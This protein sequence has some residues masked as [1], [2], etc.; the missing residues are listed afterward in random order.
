MVRGTNQMF[1]P[2]RSTITQ[3]PERLPE[4]PEQRLR[5]PSQRRN[6]SRFRPVR[7]PRNRQT[8]PPLKLRPVSLCERASRRNA[9]G[10]SAGSPDADKRAPYGSQN[11]ADQDV[12][13]TIAKRAAV[14][15]HV[16]AEATH[17]VVAGGI[18]QARQHG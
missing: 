3:P 11:G 17:L 14:S 1:K 9:P 10:A 5:Q 12:H 15:A 8:R 2:P 4:S 16:C 13:R 6:S 18:E 7:S